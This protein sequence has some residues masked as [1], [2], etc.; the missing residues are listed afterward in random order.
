M[1]NKRK[2]EAPPEGSRRSERLQTVKR[3]KIADEETTSQATPA[4]PK[5]FRRPRQRKS[6]H[7]LNLPGEIRNT[8]YRYALIKTKPMKVTSK[9]PGEPS[10]LRVCNRIRREARSIYYAENEFELHLEDFD[11]E[12][13]VPFKNQY[14]YFSNWLTGQCLGVNVTNLMKGKPNWENL[15]AWIKA[16]RNR[17]AF[18]PDI[19]REYCPTHQVAASAFRIVDSMYMRPWFE[20]E[21]AL[22]AMREVLDGMPSLWAEFPDWF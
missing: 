10:L 7:L 9:G 18:W 1:G 22:E 5:C 6:C 20:V 19:F 14:S 17:R 2:A 11:G 4:K 8:I 21:R 16:D 12:A 3:Q 13:L 15:V